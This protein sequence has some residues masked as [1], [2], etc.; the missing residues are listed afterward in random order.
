MYDLKI[1][2]PRLDRYWYYDHTQKAKQRQMHKESDSLTF[3]KSVKRDQRAGSNKNQI[4]PDG[5]ANANAQDS[6]DSVRSPTDPYHSRNFEWERR[7]SNFRPEDLG[8]EL[9]A[10]SHQSAHGLAGD[11]LN[12]QTEFEKAAEAGEIDFAA[13]M[14]ERSKMSKNV[15]DFA[16]I[17]LRLGKTGQRLDHMVMNQGGIFAADGEQQDIAAAGGADN[18]YQTQ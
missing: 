13:A 17:S 8:R 9:D 4:G 18:M 2:C 15:R 6:P 3:L 5:Q 1:V 12:S 10:C 16:R 11:S 7:Y 14:Q